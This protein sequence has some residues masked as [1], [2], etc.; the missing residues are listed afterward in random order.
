MI[1][2]LAEFAAALAVALPG[3][4]AVTASLGS[5]QTQGQGEIDERADGVRSLGVLLSA[6]C[7]EDH[8]PARVDE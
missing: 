8:R 2:L 7:G 1:C 3:E 6:P 5:R 4:T